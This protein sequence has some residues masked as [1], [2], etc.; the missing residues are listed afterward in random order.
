MPRSAPP[1]TAKPGWAMANRASS[2][3]SR[4]PAF[5]LPEVARP[6]SPAQW[7]T[8]V[9][10]GNMDRFMPP[11]ASLNDQERWDV[12]AYAMTLHMTEEQVAR[13]GKFSKQIAQTARQTS[14]QDQANVRSE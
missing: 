4:C 2:W 13:A 5:G 1:A 10:R 14:S 3:V 7:Y 9:T 6:A 12:V 8:T 11:F